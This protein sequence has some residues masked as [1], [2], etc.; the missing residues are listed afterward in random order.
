LGRISPLPRILEETDKLYP[1]FTEVIRYLARLTDSLP[2]NSREKIGRF[3]LE[4]LKG[5]VVSH[6]EFHRMQIMSLFAGSS[7]WG[8]ADKLAGFYGHLPDS[9][10]RLALLIALGRADQH[11]WLRTKKT[12]ME[13]MPIWEK[14]AFLICGELFPKL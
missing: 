6:L 9:L 1:V 12:E 2:S 11:Y 3:L 5:S 14:R 4:K 10:S 8:N 13:Q 7:K